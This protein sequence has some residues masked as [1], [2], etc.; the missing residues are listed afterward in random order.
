MVEKILACVLMFV[1]WGAATPVLAQTTDPAERQRQVGLYK[2]IAGAG[3]ATIGGLMAATSGQSATITSSGS[4]GTSTIDISSRNNSRLVM[5]LAFAG[6]GSFLLWNRNSD[7][8]EAEQATS[9]LNLGLA[10][11]GARIT[12]SRSW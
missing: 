4:Y 5:G 8:K 10:P 12:F 1:L 6:A 11:G 9:S 2:M 3:L 7:R